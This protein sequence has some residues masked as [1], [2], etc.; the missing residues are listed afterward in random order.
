VPENSNKRTP[1]EDALLRSMIEANTSVH[2]ISAKLKRSVPAIRARAS[3]L[4]ILM[5][6]VRVGLKAKNDR[7]RTK[8]VLN[9]RRIPPRPWRQA[10]PRGRLN[11]SRK[12]KREAAR[13]KHAAEEAAWAERKR[14]AQERDNAREESRYAAMDAAMAAAISIHRSGLEAAHADNSL[15]EWFDRL[16]DHCLSEA[17][18]GAREAAEEA[19]R[20]AYDATFNEIYA[21]TLSDLL[22]K[23]LAEYDARDL[24]G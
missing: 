4:N 9:A 5:K 7:G 22:A 2:L 12:A 11:A 6:W 15:P 10:M 24:V 3:M 8:D 16:L 20:R 13:A 1:E 17:Y 21:T 18:E 19:E 14:K 23:A